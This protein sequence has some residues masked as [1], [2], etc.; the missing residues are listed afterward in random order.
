M[1]YRGT[2][3]RWDDER[4][5]GFIARDDR[6]PDVFLHASECRAESRHVS[7]A[8]GTEVEFDILD[9][10]GKDRA[11]KVTGPR[12]EPLRCSGG[13]GSDRGPPPRGGGGGGGSDCYNCGR[14]GHF[15][16]ECPDKGGS[17]GGGGYD[18]RDRGRDRYDDR[19][20][21]RYDDRG[22]RSRRS[23]SRSRSRRSRSRSR[24]RRDSRDRDRYRPY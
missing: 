19:D 4:G 9:D 7:L 21:D 1:A 14:P 18:D 8:E 24:G 20:R 13:G 12:G 22:S 16:R 23:R 5:F 3:T 15:S 17:R 11:I 10:R 2:V 6:G